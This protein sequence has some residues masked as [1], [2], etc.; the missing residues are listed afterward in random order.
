[1]VPWRQVT[2][3]YL[4]ATMKSKA[5]TAPPQAYPALKASGVYPSIRDLEISI[6]LG[7]R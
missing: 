1:M 2:K 7:Y 6:A 5:E 4:S 3:S